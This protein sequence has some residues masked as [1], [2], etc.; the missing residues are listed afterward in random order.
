MNC[1]G[2]VTMAY[3]MEADKQMAAADYFLYRYRNSWLESADPRAK[4]IATFVFALALLTSGSLLCKSILLA[5]LVIAWGKG[6][7]P[8][9][10]LI[11]T[12]LS[13]SLL[14]VS[15]MIYHVLLA[16]AGTGYG[17]K[18]IVSGL[19]MCLQ[20]AGLMVLLALLVHATAPLALAEGI[21]R[22]LAPLARR[23]LPVHEA[24]LMFTIALQFI[25]ILLTEFDLIRKAQIARGGGFHRGSVLRR[26]R[27]VIPIL[28]PMIVRSI[29]RAEELATAMESR[30]YNGGAGR[31]SLRVYVW[32]RRDTLLLVGSTVLAA[33]STADRIW[34]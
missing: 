7:L 13:M 6:R 25:P 16:D 2:S 9:R 23:K 5:I 20:I 1:C 24:V 18:G 19:A 31:T 33:L 8:W 10:L 34:L 28:M 21:E 15:T 27:G 32:R 4:M 11:V 14:F 17:N 3:G 12:L 30:C 26:V 29:V 22:M